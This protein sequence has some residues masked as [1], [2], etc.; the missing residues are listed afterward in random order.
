MSRW[1]GPKLGLLALAG[2]CSLSCGS[3]SGLEGLLGDPEDRQFA[4]EPPPAVELEPPAAP[5]VL[6]PMEEPSGCVDFTRSYNSVPSTVMLLIDQSG[7][8]DIRF[9]GSTRWDVLR[10]AIVEP[11]NGL[12]AWLEPTASIGLML[13]T[14]VD[15]YQT[16]LDCPLFTSIEVSFGGAA[17]MRATYRAAEPLEVGDTPT[18]EAIDGAAQRLLALADDTRKYILLVTDGQPDTCAQP[19]P[20]NGLPNAIAAA[21]NAFAQGITVRTVGVSEDIARNTIQA[22]ANAG[23]GKPAWDLRYGEDEGAERPLFASTDPA[24]LAEQLKGV[25]GDVRTCTIELGTRVQ[26]RRALDGRLVL[27]G[28]ALEFGAADGWTFVDDD[29]LQIHGAACDSILADGEQLHV[30]FPC[31]DGTPIR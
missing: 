28:A 20:Q 5:P 9:G 18:G 25:I 4:V 2:A 23:V 12:L 31:G 16:G 6:P 29:T 13:Y 24:E 19:D 17:Q 15:G 7:S 22:M 26:T 30:R 8:M 10:E 14:S 3:R 27:D 21:Q 11:Q 1:S